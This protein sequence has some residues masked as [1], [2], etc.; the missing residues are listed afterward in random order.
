MDGDGHRGIRQLAPSSRR[1]IATLVILIAM[2]MGWFTWP[3]DAE[4]TTPA[5]T[6][7]GEVIAAQALRD[8]AA[9]FA[10]TH[11]AS[12]PATEP[13]PSTQMDAPLRVE[14]A[15]TGWCWVAAESDGKR[16]LYRLLEPGEHVVLEGWR[17]ISLRLGNAGS[18]AVSVND[19]PRRAAGG[20][21][22]VVDLKFTR[23][24]REPLRDSQVEAVSGD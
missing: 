5:A 9:A 11:K 12:E 1:P 22:E 20:D 19:G 7:S 23:D 10:A 13:A 18:V 4:L 15:A 21:G 16:A 24:D 6:R 8:A 17:T 2:A 14:L 3:D